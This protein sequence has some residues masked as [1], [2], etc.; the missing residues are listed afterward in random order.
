M[1]ILDPI[2]IRISPPNIS[3]YRLNFGPVFLPSRIPSIDAINVTN[4]IMKTGNKIFSIKVE[5]LNP[6]ARASILV[7]SESS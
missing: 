1:R 4:P 7:A 6:T 5:K 3:A 2:R